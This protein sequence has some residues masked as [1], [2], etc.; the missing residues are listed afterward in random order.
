MIGPSHLFNM[1][2]LISQQSAGS[3]GSASVKNNGYFAH[4]ENVL[5][6]MLEDYDETIRRKAA[7]KI[8]EVRGK[9]PRTARAKRAQGIRWFKYP[10]L[11]WDA[12]SYIDMFDWN[13][14]IFTEPAITKKMTNE[15]L[16]ASY[17]GPLNFPMYPAHNQSV[18]CFLKLT[19][20]A[21]HTMYGEDNRNK[22]IMSKVAAK[23][24]EN[25]LTTNVSTRKE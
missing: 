4:Y 10:T 7:N 9:K 3:G 25:R 21:S 5:P 11:N 12:T 13:S 18:E 17:I 2:K 15:E 20:D 8:I 16:M 6:V 14:T 24:R 23:V 22:L 19:S 1:M